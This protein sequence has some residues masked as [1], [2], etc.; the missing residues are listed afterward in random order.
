MMMNTNYQILTKK[1]R[2][3]EKREGGGGKKRGVGD[4]KIV[5]HFVQVNN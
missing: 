4:D 5:L 3:K 2:K 1:S